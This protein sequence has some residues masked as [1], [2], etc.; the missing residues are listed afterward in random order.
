MGTC[1]QNANED[2]VF[3]QVDFGSPH[4]DLI[5]VNSDG[6]N[7][8]QSEKVDDLIVKWRQQVDIP[9]N[10]DEIVV[11]SFCGT[12]LHFKTFGDLMY[13]LTGK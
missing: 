11:C 3:S 13:A 5:T 7:V 6:A 1:N 2:N 9:A 4:V 12:P 8:F 10:D